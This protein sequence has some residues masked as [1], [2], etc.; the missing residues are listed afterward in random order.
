[1]PQA[2]SSIAESFPYPLVDYTKP[3]VDP[4]P[5]KPTGWSN[6]LAHHPDH[7]YRHTLLDI[8]KYG[9]RVGY[10]GLDQKILS[11][12][13]PTATDAPH[14]LQ[15]YLTLQ[16]KK[17]RVTRLEVLPSRFISSPLGVEPKPSGGWRQI[18]HLSHPRDKSVNCHIPVEHGALE[19]TSVDEAIELIL[20]MGRG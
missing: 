12:N 13:L 2:L 4:C 18:Q 16:L 5:L 9:A 17:N 15:D 11:T 8:I 20:H 3:L 6:L 14:I 1:M 7:T 10:Q 19:Y